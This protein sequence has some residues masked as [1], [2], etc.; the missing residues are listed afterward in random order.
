M[1]G[2]RPDNMNLLIFYKG[3]YW[4]VWLSI[5]LPRFIQPVEV[6]FIRERNNSQSRRGT[7]GV[8]DF[9]AQIMALFIAGPLFLLPVAAYDERADHISS[10]LYALAIFPVIPVMWLHCLRIMNEKTSAR[11]SLFSDEH[12]AKSN[13]QTMIWRCIFVTCLTYIIICVVLSDH[14]LSFLSS[15]DDTIN[16]SDETSLS[17]DN[18][19]DASSNASLNGTSVG[20]LTEGACQNS[21]SV[22]F[23]FLGVVARMRTFTFCMLVHSMVAVYLLCL[24]VGGSDQEA[25]AVFFGFCKVY[26]IAILTIYNTRLRD[27]NERCTWLQSQKSKTAISALKSKFESRKS[28]RT[29]FTGGISRRDSNYE[30][31]RNS[32]KHAKSTEDLRGAPAQKRASAKFTSDGND[33]GGDNSDRKSVSNDLSKSFSMMS[34][35]SVRSLNSQVGG[36]GQSIRELDDGL[37]SVLEKNKN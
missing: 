16:L 18:E 24:V 36:V 21:I 1:I 29:S 10:I 34:R 6:Q 26:G 9:N 30:R 37:D 35:S 32:I 8:F 31:V 15:I 19:F 12:P 17:V 2:S 14:R 22:L 33:G 13:L 28:L 25:F 4:P 3:K 20:L 7:N 11:I 5:L 23:V 27:A